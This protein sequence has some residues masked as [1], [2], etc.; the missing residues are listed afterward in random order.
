MNDQKVAKLTDDLIEGVNTGKKG[1][2][3][4]M[5]SEQGPILY[6]E[7]ATYLV[8]RL[9][10]KL[11]D[12]KGNQ[13]AFD[14]K[15]VSFCCCFRQGTCLK[16]KK[17]AFLLMD[18]NEQY[19]LSSK[20]DWVDADIYAQA[21]PVRHKDGDALTPLGF[22]AHFRKRPDIEGQ[23]RD[24]VVAVSTDFQLAWLLDSLSDYVFGEAFQTMQGVDEDE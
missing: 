15:S 17:A 9:F 7:G 1:Y 12:G 20:E 16:P 4:I 19:I 6:S 8:T 22:W 21:V 11:A 24:H 3:S 23:V 2:F 5:Q 10:A 13:T 14:E 18:E